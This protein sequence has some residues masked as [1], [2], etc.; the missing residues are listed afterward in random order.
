MFRLDIRGQTNTN[1]KRQWM[2]Q[3]PRGLLMSSQVCVRPPPPLPLLTSLS[4]DS[5]ARSSPPPRAPHFVCCL[6]RESTTECSG[7]LHS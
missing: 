4:R 2:M 5:I 7:R 3:I 1:N 6:P